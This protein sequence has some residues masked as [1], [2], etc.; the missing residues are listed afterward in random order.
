MK[1]W[2][3]IGVAEGISA[4]DAWRIAHRAFRKLKR[5]HPDLLRTLKFLASQLEEIRQQKEAYR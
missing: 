4:Q 3:E 1:T 5:K 2:Q